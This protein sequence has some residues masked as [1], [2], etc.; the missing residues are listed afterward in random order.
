MDV[1]LATVS[2]D[3]GRF[4]FLNYK[5]GNEITALSFSEQFKNID[6]KDSNDYREIFEKI[7]NP[8]PID[9]IKIIDAQKE[10][11]QVKKETRKEPMSLSRIVWIGISILALFILLIFSF[12]W[13]IFKLFNYKAKHTKAIPQKAYWSY[14][15][16]TYY[17]NQLG[18]FKGMK[19]HQHNLQ[20]KKLILNLKRILLRLCRCI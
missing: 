9:E 7:P 2:K 10:K 19:C 4:R 3:T 13:L 15:A 11:Q 5:K 17:L 20:K 14:N 12:P 8:A 16:A 1:S 18:F 6:L